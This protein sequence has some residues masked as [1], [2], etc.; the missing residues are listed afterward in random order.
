MFKTHG[1]TRPPKMSS[2]PQNTATGS[3]SRP[4]GGTMKTMTSAP[5][6]PHKLDSR[7]VKGA[8]K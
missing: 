7:H 8:L 2:A 6:H 3:G 5:H 1:G 4:N